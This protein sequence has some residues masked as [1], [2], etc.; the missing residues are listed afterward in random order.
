VQCKIPKVD[1]PNNLLT[2]DPGDT[3]GLAFWEGTE[4]PWTYSFHFPSKI[5]DKI[6]QL[7]WMTMQFEEIIKHKSPERIIIEEVQFW[8]GS[9]T[10]I[11][12]AKRRDL[13][14][15]SYLIGGY[16]NCC[17][18]Q[19]ID[20]IQLVL[21]QDWKGQMN[22]AAVASRVYL[23]NGRRYPNP[24]VCDAVGMGLNEVGLFKYLGRDLKI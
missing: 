22:D 23:L 10:S 1:F 5:R 21:S 17:H 6:E 24:H 11:T 12:A 3:T 2:V 14:K 19:W 7:N 9:L 8:A 4:N 13:F 16:I 15:L 18:H 20:K